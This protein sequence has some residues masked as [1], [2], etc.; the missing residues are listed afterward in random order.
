MR[1]VGPGTPSGSSG[2]DCDNDPDPPPPPEPEP[3]PES[4]GGGGDAGGLSGPTAGGSNPCNPQSK[5]KWYNGAICPAGMAKLGEATLEGGEIQ[6]LCQ[7]VGPPPDCEPPLRWVCDSTTGSCVQST[8]GIYE[9]KEE[10]E[11]AG[12]K[13]IRYACV[14]GQCLQTEGGN[15]ATY[16]DCLAS[17]CQASM[18]RRKGEGCGCELSPEGTYSTE[19]DCLST[20]NAPRQLLRFYFGDPSTEFNW[21]HEACL[22]SG[23]F[24]RK[25]AEGDEFFDFWEW[26]GC[27]RTESGGVIEV[28]M[29]PGWW[30]NYAW[31]NS[32]PPPYITNVTIVGPC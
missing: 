14:S 17:R 12:C 31:D 23:P 4:S 20:Y 10:C 13:I 16:E 29:D 11:A 5:V 24:V 1:F 27:T 25:R 9:T 32:Y 22:I 30:W 6:S 3:E 21:L 15:Y 2:P 18:W 26:Y 28:V 8:G 7:G 19:Q